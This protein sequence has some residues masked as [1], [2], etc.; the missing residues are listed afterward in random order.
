[1]RKTNDDL[2]AKVVGAEIKRLRVARGLSLRKLAAATNLDFGYVGKIERGQGA[3]TQTYRVLAAALGA[4][5]SALF[6]VVPASP[7]IDDKRAPKGP[8]HRGPKRLHARSIPRPS[9]RA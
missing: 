2:T 3:A 8:K 6:A 4:T 9:L 7:S 1:M 5:L